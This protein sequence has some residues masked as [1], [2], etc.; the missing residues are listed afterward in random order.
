M[1]P[2]I[3]NIGGIDYLIVA[4]PLQRPELSSTGKTLIV[5]KTG[6][7]TKAGVNVA[8]KPVTFTVSAWIPK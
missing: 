5:A 6:V 4:V 7:P 2:E 1:N 3:K 8:G